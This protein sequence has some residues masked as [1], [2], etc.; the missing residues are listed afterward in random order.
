MGPARRGRGE[1]LHPVLRGAGREEEAGRPSQE[2]RERS[3]RAAP[4]DRPGPRRRVD[5][6]AP[7]RGTAAENPGAA[8][9]LPRDHRGR[10]Q[11]G[12]P[13]SVRDQ[14]EPGSRPG[15]PPH[16]R[17]AL[18]LHAL[19][20]PVE[21][22]AD[23]SQRRPRAE[24]RRPPHRRTGRGAAGVPVGR[25]LGPR[26]HAAGRGARVRGHAH[27]AGR[28]ADRVGQGL[29][30]PDR[31]AQ[32]PERAP[33]RR[34]GRHHAGRGGAAERAVAGHVGRGQARVRAP[35]GAVHDLHPHAGSQ[36]Q[37]RVL[38]R[39]HDADCPAPVPGHG[40]RRR[41]D[42]PHHL[43]PHRLDDAL[44]QSAERVGPGHQ[45]DVRRRV[46]RRAAALSDPGEERAGSARGHSSRGVPSRAQSARTRARLRR[47]QGLRVDLEAHHGVADGGR[48][49]AAHDHRA[50]GQGRQ[51]RAGGVQ[52]QRQGDR[53]RRLPPRLRRGVG[54]SGR[55]AGRAGEHPAA[56]QGR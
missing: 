39:A 24:R 15:E 51:R 20:R 26:G 56:V 36:P 10:R 31:C 34:S 2:R 44:R 46:L 48:A 16:P 9:G 22:G 33:A 7:E 41:R 30:R 29:R 43:S 25:L 55:G 38:H 4:G 53:V 32:E 13:E 28:Q 5:Q 40:H 42:G 1:Q 18:R 14:R 8:P 17:P 19:A 21:E 11:R 47:P 35:G 6:L 54:R 50:H 23:R 52:R 12:A 49:R 27:P 3:V 37:A 45:G